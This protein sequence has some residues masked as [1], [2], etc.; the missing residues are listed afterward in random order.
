[1]VAG[2]V[3]CCMAFIALRDII[4]RSELDAMNA[5]RG[6]ARSIV[7]A[8]IGLTAGSGWLAR[9]SDGE[10]SGFLAIVLGRSRSGLVFYDFRVGAVS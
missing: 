10:S 2:F 8:A 6:L 9:E 4:L 3:Q 1:V 5:R 7:T